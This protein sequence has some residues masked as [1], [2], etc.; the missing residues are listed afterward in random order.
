MKRYN[1][2]LITILCV[3]LVLCVGLSSTGCY[4]RSTITPPTMPSSA[5]TEPQDE[6]YKQKLDEILA[7]LDQY[8]VDDYSTEK[9]GDYLAEAAIASTGDRWSYYISAEDYAAYQEGNA[10]AYVGIGVTIQMTNDDDPGFTIVSVAHG[11]PAEAAGLQI[12]DMIVAVEGENAVEMGMTEAQHRVRGEE[13]TDI[14]ITILRGDE[15]FDVTITRQRIEIDVVVYELLE[16]NVGY[17]K[18]NNFDTHSS[19][20]AIAAIKDLT[21]QGADCLIFDLRFNPGGMKHELVALLDYLLPEGPLFR[22]VDYKGKEEVDY[23]DADFIDL[24][25]AVLINDDSYSAA[26]FFAAALQE[27]EA[28]VIV[29]TKTC[30]KA[31]YQQTFRLSDG[32]AIAVSTGHYQ[33]PHGV[34]LA[35]VGVTPDVIVEVDEETYLNL[36]YEKITR[37]DDEQLQAAIDALGK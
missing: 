25:M 14:T 21:A 10:N 4:I 13:G 11:S 1:S 34:T 8:Y 36:Y 26:E 35:D 5:P 31:N 12:D 6:A 15:E 24:P 16:N 33:T 32:S 29:G 9:L 23:S 22:S 3:L 30:G 19:R 37:E 18:I 28:G 7:I 2:V 17:I 27:Y 20:D